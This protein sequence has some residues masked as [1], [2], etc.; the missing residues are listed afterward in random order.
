M[1]ITDMFMYLT[2]E[3]DVEDIDVEEERCHQ[4]R[5]IQR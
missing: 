3:A 2:D 1:Y 4:E 5:G